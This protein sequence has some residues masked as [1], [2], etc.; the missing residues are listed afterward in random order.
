MIP[1]DEPPYYA[2]KMSGW[3]L[4]TSPWIADHSA[5]NRAYYDAES[6]KMI[7]EADVTNYDL[8]YADMYD[9]AADWMLSRAAWL[10]E[11]FAAY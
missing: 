6:K 5:L 11:Q 7:V 4:C 8:I 2:A 10:S 9:Y 3:L 1:I